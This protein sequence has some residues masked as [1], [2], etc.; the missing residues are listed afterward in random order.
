VIAAP[1]PPP[2][3]GAVLTPRSRRCRSRS[4][5]GGRQAGAS[6]PRERRAGRLRFNRLVT[7]RNVSSPPP[8][9]RPGDDE[10]PGG[11][12]VPDLAH[13]GPAMAACLRARAAFPAATRPQQPHWRARYD[14]ASPDA[15]R[16]HASPRRQERA[17]R[18]R[19]SPPSRGGRVCSAG[20]PGH[21]RH[22]GESE[23]SPSAASPPPSADRRVRSQGSPPR[24]GESAAARCASLAASVSRYQVSGRRHCRCPRVIG[25]M[26]AGRLET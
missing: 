12:V 25:T 13:C 24:S 6:S 11:G 23:P 2:R 26:S 15:V 1:I 20:D 21:V 8:R 14:L 4:P 10:P 22:R 5:D 9:P 7:R 16:S 3:S 17:G 19:A 18:G